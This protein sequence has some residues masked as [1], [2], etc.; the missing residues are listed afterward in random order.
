MDI[1]D[2]TAAALSR[3]SMLK[4]SAAATLLLSQAALLEQV[5]ISPARPAFA[6]GFTDI[7][8]ELG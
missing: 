8:F 6:A 5:L 4:K 1:E 2:V 3:R 7:Q